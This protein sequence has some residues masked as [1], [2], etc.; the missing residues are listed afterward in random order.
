MALR[1]AYL[2]MH[3]MTN[4]CLLETGITADQFVCM[5]ILYDN[6]GITQQELAKRAAS[7]ANT[8]RAMLVLLE[9][10]EYIIRKDHPGDGRAF[11]VL[12][13]RKG[14]A[15]YEKCDAALQPV[16]ARMFNFMG[17]GEADELY[18]QLIRMT[19]ELNK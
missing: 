9:K 17:K 5:S 13:T 18:S 11:H 7:D 12:L 4:Q 8:I 6:P 1:A 3:R 2:S 14:K 10:K 15:I 16:R 19:D